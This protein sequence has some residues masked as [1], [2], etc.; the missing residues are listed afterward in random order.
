[1]DVPCRREVGGSMEMNGVKLELQPARTPSSLRRCAATRW[2]RQSIATWLS[3]E[4]HIR[5][6]N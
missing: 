6:L 5:C 3:V 2:L 4:V 1:M